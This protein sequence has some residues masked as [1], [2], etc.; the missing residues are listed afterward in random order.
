MIVRVLL[1]MPILRE[2]AK[3]FKMD[4]MKAPNL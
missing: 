1:S 3:K 4:D 2:S